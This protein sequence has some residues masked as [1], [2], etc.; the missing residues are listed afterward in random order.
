MERTELEVL[1]EQL[2]EM[3]GGGIVDADDALELAALA[4]LATRLGGS[5]GALDEVMNWRVTIGQPMLDEAWTLIELDDFIEAIDDC[6]GGDATELEI[7]EAVFDFDEV[8]AA[9]VWCG[10]E[11][12][13]R[14]AARKVEDLV[15]MVPDVFADLAPYGSEMAARPE[16]AQHLDVYG[17]WLAL[18]DAG[19]YADE[20]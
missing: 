12:R 13:V 7:E 15:R 3:L 10:E 11:A 19:A 2:E 6:T 8:V 9:A 16:V 1:L 14:E 18:S 4:G 20:D 17:Y 5:G